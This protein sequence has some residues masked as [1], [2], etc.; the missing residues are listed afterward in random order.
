MNK[1]NSEFE[2]K[3]CNFTYQI[4]TILVGI[5]GDSVSIKTLFSYLMDYDKLVELSKATK[6]TQLAII[7]KQSGRSE[8]DQLVI[9]TKLA[10][11]CDQPLIIAT[12]RLGWARASEKDMELILGF[13]P[14]QNYYFISLDNNRTKYLIEK[15]M[16]EETLK[17]KINEMV[18]ETFYFNSDEVLTSKALA[19]IKEEFTLSDDF[20]DKVKY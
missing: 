19:F 4:V 10:K 20:F 2:Q 5:L 8:F 11:Q 9:A 17:F 18:L 12:K 7:L 1:I 3:Q 6:N 15:T 14:S 16:H 13:E